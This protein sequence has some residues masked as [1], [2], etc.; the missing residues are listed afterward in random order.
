MVHERAGN[1]SEAVAALKEAIELER[2]EGVLA[3]YYFELGALHEKR[4]ERDL[5]LVSFEE[6]RKLSNILSPAFR[7]DLEARIRRIACAS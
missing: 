5:A 3:F 7:A 2:D 1:T 6:S 4:A